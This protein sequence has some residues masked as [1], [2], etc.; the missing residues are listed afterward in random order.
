[1]PQK[2]WRRFSKGAPHGSKVN[3]QPSHGILSL[4][5]KRDGETNWYEGVQLLA[6]YALIA[7]A[8]YYLPMEKRAPVPAAPAA[9]AV[10]AG[11]PR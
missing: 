1:M 6:M 3:N 9:I 5:L 7:V 8:L 4:M 10:P 2:G 11:H